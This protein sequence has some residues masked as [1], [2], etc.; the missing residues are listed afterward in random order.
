MLQTYPPSSAWVNAPFASRRV[1]SR[2]CAAASHC[3]YIL[4]LAHTLH[5][6]VVV[7]N[8]K[9]IRTVTDAIAAG[10]QDALQLHPRTAMLLSRP[11]APKAPQ[12]IRLRVQQ[13]L[14]ACLQ[15]E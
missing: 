8:P 11:T 9:P 13:S 2:K 7:E 3:V 14:T 5:Q 12:R 6:T 15:G 1:S 10:A 4:D